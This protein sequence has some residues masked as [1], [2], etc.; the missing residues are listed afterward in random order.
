MID[1]FT[2]ARVQPEKNFQVFER[3]KQLPMVKDARLVYGEY[4]IILRTTTKSMKELNQFTYNL[5]RKV[6][7]VT[8]T[9]TMIVARIPAED[10]TPENR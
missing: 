6:H 4:D 1:A 10:P 2:L 8:K 9:T 5:V 3:I 7:F